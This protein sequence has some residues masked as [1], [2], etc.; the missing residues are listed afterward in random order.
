M[1]ILHLHIVAV[2]FCECECFTVQVLFYTCKV[3]DTGVSV[4]FQVLSGNEV[5]A[6]RD[7]MGSL[8]CIAW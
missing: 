4:E 6:R 5:L 1:H 8:V 3:E 7:E 2:R